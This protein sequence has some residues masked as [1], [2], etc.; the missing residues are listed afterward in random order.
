[1]RIVFGWSYFVLKSYRLSELIVTDD[2]SLKNAEL[3]VREAY[4]H[5][6][7]IPFF[8]PWKTLPHKIGG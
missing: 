4:F 6:F 3:V 8:F 2:E 1:M 5:I 7:W